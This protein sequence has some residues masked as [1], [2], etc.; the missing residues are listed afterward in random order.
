MN[1]EQTD[2]WIK[3]ALIFRN[4]QVKNECPLAKIQTNHRSH[5]H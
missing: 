5:I 4:S 2:K 3:T 1:K